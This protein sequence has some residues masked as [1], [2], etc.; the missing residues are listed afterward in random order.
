M[1][2]GFAVGLGGLCNV[3]DRDVAGTIVTHALYLSLDVA[4]LS[5]VPLLI[6]RCIRTVYAAHSVALAAPLF[7]GCG[8]SMVASLFHENTPSESC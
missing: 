3:F 6:L 5:R 1:R 4:A 2:K 7:G 8:A